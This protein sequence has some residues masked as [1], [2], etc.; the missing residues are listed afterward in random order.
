MTNINHVGYFSFRRPDDSP[1]RL[2]YARVIDFSII[3]TDEG[4]SQPPVRTLFLPNSTLL[5]RSPLGDPGQSPE[6]SL[7]SHCHTKH[8]FQHQHH[9]PPV[10]EPKWR[11]N[12]PCRRAAHLVPESVAL[13]R[14]GQH[15]ARQSVPGE[16][17][18]I[19]T[20]VRAGACGSR[21]FAEDQGGGFWEGERGVESDLDRACELFVGGHG[22]EGCDGQGDGTAGRKGSEDFGRSGVE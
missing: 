17:L 5:Q 1:P 4:F 21:R 19:E 18:A 10:F 3:R 13:F 7:L 2:R 9:S 16:V 6:R 14:R 12:A 8:V 22:V 11:Q 20:S 15:F